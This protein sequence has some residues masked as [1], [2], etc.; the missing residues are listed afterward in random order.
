MSL[1]P[2]EPLSPAPGLYLTSVVW[3]VKPLLPQNSGGPSGG[4]TIPHCLA[5]HTPGERPLIPSIT[6]VDTAPHHEAACRTGGRAV[7]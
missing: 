4:W 1:H 5:T 2:H 3:K 6:E 7:S